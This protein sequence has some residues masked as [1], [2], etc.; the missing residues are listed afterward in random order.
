[1]QPNKGEMR[2]FRF[3]S[4]GET[5]LVPPVSGINLRMKMRRQHPPPQ[6]P[7]VAVEIG[8]KKVAE[9]NYADPDY[10]VAMRI[11]EREIG[12][13]VTDVVL[14]RI[15][16]VQKLRER[17][18]D[19][20]KELRDALAGI[21]E[22]HE[23]DKLVWFYEIALGR[24]DEALEMMKLATGQSDPTEDGVQLETDSFRGDVQGNG[25]LESENVN[26]RDTVSQPRDGM[27]FDSA[28]GG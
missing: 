13:R 1:M 10:P 15:A 20:V 12:E 5:V 3:K 25:H 2:Q 4:T 22:L 19:R 7:L 14:Q 18:R 23:N 17:D 26:E 11:Y 6:P 28:M 24:D 21:E 16:A 8:G 27:D 9:R